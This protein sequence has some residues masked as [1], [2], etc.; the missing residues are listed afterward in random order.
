MLYHIITY[1]CQMN[2]SDSERIAV[3]LE[4]QGYKP[5]KNS[6][7]AGLIVINA[8]SV[9]QAA[10]HRAYDKINKFRKENKK[11]VLAGCVLDADKKKLKDK[12][13]EFWSPDKYFCAYTP[14]SSASVPRNSALI[15]IMTGCNNFCSYCVVPYTR[16][17]EKSRSADE[18]IKEVKSLVKNG[19]KEIILLGQNVNSYSGI[20]RESAR[21]RGLSSATPVNFPRLLQSTNN[22]P[23]NFTI[24]FLTSHPK[25]MSDELINTIA[26]CK[27]VSREIHLPIQSGDDTILKKMNRKYTAAHYEKLVKKIRAQI[28][29]AV[30]STDII[31]GFPGE[32]KKQFNNTLK[33]CRSIK[34]AKAYIAQYSPRLGTAAYKLKDNVLKKEKKCRWKILDDLVNKKTA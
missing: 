13:N 5:A 1:G 22:T 8:C 9:R 16:G 33:L 14:H 18:I 6:E 7:K 34:F 25:D 19:A 11:I 31:V 10:M 15:P 27:K 3:M 23:G 4:K 30:I 2:H 20:A 17:R 12:I 32:T 26:E 29:D 24:K 21:R 28:P